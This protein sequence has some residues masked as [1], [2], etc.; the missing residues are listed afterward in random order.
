MN[1]VWKQKIQ[2]FT[3]WVTLF[4]MGTDLFIVS[5]LLPA[6]A[7]KYNVSPS[8]A[9]W[10]VTVF[11]LMYA[12]GAPF[13]GLLS[14]KWGRRR[15]IVIGLTG[16]TI[17]NFITGIA[18][19]FSVLLGSRILAGLTASMVS[20]SVFA[21]VG[22]SAPKGKSG[23]WLSIATSGFLTALWTGAPIGTIVGQAFGWRVAFIGLA[24][25][26]F[27]F[28]S[29]NMRIWPQQSTK[30]V[31]SVLPARDT[32]KHILLEVAVTMFW[33][34]GIYGLYTYLGTGLASVNHFSSGLVATALVTYGVGAIIGSLS[35]GKLADV[36][37]V[38]AVPTLALAV[39]AF[40][41]IGLG[42]L[43]DNII[44]IWPMLTLVGLAGYIA[45]SAFQARLA[46]LFP[47]RL[48]TAM[49]WNQTAM[50]AGITLGSVFGSLYLSS[51]SFMTWTI[52]CGVSALIASLWLLMRIKM[53][54]ASLYN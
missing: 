40:A 8:T 7:D 26:S 10:M 11:S 53:S 39:L 9:G 36:W 2:L 4:L 54:K 14:D 34:G 18:P 32:M 51:G 13:F 49:A 42:L 1:R 37:N 23:Q 3:A 17:A 52:L 30:L 19:T 47:D 24:I 43:F 15:M 33:A 5:P 35:G 45:F 41:L 6:I 27:L 50:Y 12:L 46:V 38:R 25:L 28:M 48:G 16:F 22:D 31:T 21:I 29:L 44:G 20:S